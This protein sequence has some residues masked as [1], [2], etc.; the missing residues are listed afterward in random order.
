VETLFGSEAG[1][2][3]RKRGK[4]WRFWLFVLSPFLILGMCGVFFVKAKDA[5]QQAEHE[6]AL[7]RERLE[8]AQDDAIWASAAPALQASTSQLVFSQYLDGIHDKM[9]SCSV[10]LKPI[11]YFANANTS[12][13]TVR[14]QY[15]VKCS[16]GA[17]DEAF[18]F[19][20]NGTMM[21]LLDYQASSPFLQK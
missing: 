18:T 20:K 8:S 17:L 6:V 19:A 10:P 2:E 9:G 15:R 7:F 13:T 3:S 12:G 1:S 5:G 4:S 14:L 11:T 21:A 16:K